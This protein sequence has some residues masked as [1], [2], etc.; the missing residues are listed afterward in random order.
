L[1]PTSNVLGLLPVLPLVSRHLV[2]ESVV[3]RNERNEE[4]KRPKL[5][6]LNS[7]QTN[8]LSC[9]REREREREREISSSSQESEV[10]GREERVLTVH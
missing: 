8:G 7:T 10:G 1:S 9:R 3:E 6:P 4:R 2:V 5:C